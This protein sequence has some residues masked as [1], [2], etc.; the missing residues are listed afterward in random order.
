MGLGKPRENEW[1]H[2]PMMLRHIPFADP[3]E[4]LAQPMPHSANRKPSRLVNPFFS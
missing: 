4:K 1:Q 3:Q 2:S